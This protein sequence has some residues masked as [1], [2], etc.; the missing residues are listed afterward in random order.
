V[1]KLLAM[2]LTFLLVAFALLGLRQHR[3]ELTSESAAIFNRIRE[4][5]H[6]LLDQ[7]VQITRQTNP[8]AIA[9]ALQNA[10]VNTGEALRPRDTK[11]GKPANGPAVPAVETDLLAPLFND[12][13]GHGNPAR[14]R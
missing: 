3:L 11:L 5:Q 1:F 6:T 10:G 2:L 9:T 8:W 12:G 4:R 7:Q 14:P 13:S